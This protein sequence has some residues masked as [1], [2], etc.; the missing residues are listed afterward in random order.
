MRPSD[1]P[2][3]CTRSMPTWTTSALSRRGGRCL[4]AGWGVRRCRSTRCCGCCTGTIATAGLREPVP[5]GGRLDL[6]AAVLPPRP[7]SAGAAPDHAGQAGPAR[8]P[9]HGRAAQQRPAR[10]AG[11]GQAAAR[12]QAAGGHHRGGGRQRLPDRRRPAG[13]GGPKAWWAGA[14]HQGARRGH[15][16]AVSGPWSSSGP[17]EAAVGPHA[18]AA[19]WQAMAE[20]DRLTGE[21]ARIAKRS[22]RQVQVVARNARRALARRPDDG[23][24]GR[25]VGEL[26]ETIAATGRLAWQTDQRLAGDRVI[27]DRL[28][29][30][31]DPDARPIRKGKPGRPTEFGYTLLLAEEEH[32]FIADH[33]L[34]QG[35]PRTR[36]SWCRRSSGSSRSPAR[37]RAWCR[38]PRVWHRRQRPGAGSAGRQA[39]RPAT[40]RH[41]G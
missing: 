26:E 33:R 15:Q 10:Q 3:S 7:G 29:S 11:R 8:R 20:V 25:L 12:P 31:S 40:H 34:E 9:E 22:L 36:R 28:V 18:A 4:T 13:A 6:V 39:H 35:N 1:C 24:L 21:V 30:L 5:R 32:G 41:P 19:Q 23:R 37:R 14:A 2:P 27:A 38:R 17:A 16:D